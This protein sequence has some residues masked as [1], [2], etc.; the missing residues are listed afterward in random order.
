MVG[1][2]YGVK[3]SILDLQL[4]EV[5]F[6]SPRDF[7]TNINKDEYFVAGLTIFIIILVFIILGSM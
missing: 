2:L 4:I 3:G 1:S 6:E 5:G 7:M